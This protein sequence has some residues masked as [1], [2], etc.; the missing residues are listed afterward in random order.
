MRIVSLS[1]DCTTPYA[2]KRLLFILHTHTCLWNRYCRSLLL[3]F[4]NEVLCALCVSQPSNFPTALP[5]VYL[6]EIVINSIL[7]AYKR[8]MGGSQGDV[9]EEPVTWENRKKGWKMSCDIDDVTER[10]ENELHLR[11]SSFSSPSFALHNLWYLL[12]RLARWLSGERVT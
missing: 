10:L 5:V 1:S 6:H 2:C 3:A 12:G 11:H 9:S 7:Y 8:I 4:S